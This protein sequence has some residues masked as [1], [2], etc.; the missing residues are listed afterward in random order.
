MAYEFFGNVRALGASKI[1]MFRIAGYARFL[2]FLS[3]S[4]FTQSPA[5]FPVRVI[6]LWAFFDEGVRTLRVDTRQ[7]AFDFQILEYLEPGYFCP[8]LQSFKVLGIADRVRDFLQ[9]I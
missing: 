9:K 8:F 1:R 6:P 5:P 2:N 4:D 3:F 7:F